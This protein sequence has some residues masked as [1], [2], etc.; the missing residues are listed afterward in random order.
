MARKDFLKVLTDVGGK[1]LVDAVKSSEKTHDQYVKR[2]TPKA[3]THPWR[4]VGRVRYVVPYERG[5][6]FACQ[7]G[8]VELHWIAN[9]CLRVRLRRDN[10]DFAEPFSYAVHKTEWPLV[11]FE[12]V[13]GADAVEVRSSS[14]I[15]RV[16]KRAFRI[17]LESVE[18]QPICLDLLG[19]TFRED[20]I[21]RLSMAMQP[22][23]SSFGLGEHASELMVRGKR[24]T[25]WNSDPLGYVRGTQPLY[26][27]IPFY[28]GIHQQAVYGVFWDNPSRGFADVGASK[29]DEL[30]L[31]SESG[32]LRY[33]LFTGNDV[34]SVVGR[35][36]ELT[37]RIPLPPLWSL[38]YHHASLNI[39][40]QNVLVQ[41]AQEFRAREIPCDALYLDLPHMDRFRSFTWDKSRFPQP[42][43]TLD[44][45]GEQGFKPVA[46][47]HPGVAVDGDNAIYNSGLSH[48]LFLKYPD[49][50]AV[51]GADWSGY[52]AFPDFTNPA[53]RG[54]W[55]ELVSQL[56][57]LG[58]QG[59]LNDA[60][61]PSR[62]A[63]DGTAS[64]AD[65]IPHNG[66]G[67]GGDHLSHHNLYGLLMSRASFEGQGRARPQARPFNLMRAGFAGG[68]R[69][70]GSWLGED[71]SDWDNLR[72]SISMA[73]NM[74]LSGAPVT[75]PNIGGFYQNATGELFTRWM[76][77]ACLM[78]FFRSHSA[79]GTQP[80]EPWAFGQPY[81][82]IN[83]LTIGLRYRLI[84][85]LY[86][87]VAQCREYGWP[88]IRPLFMTEPRNPDLRSIDDCYMLGDALLVAPV[89][90]QGA[91]K[92]MVYL[93]VGRWYDYWTGELLQG[94]QSVSIA[95]PLERLPLFVRAGAV[96]PHWPEMNYVGEKPIETLVYRVYPGEFETVLYEDDGHSLNYLE[97]DYRWIYIAS[98]WEENRFVIKRRV[99]GRYTP[100]YKNIK[101]E[102]IGFDQEP[103]HILVDRQGAPL[104]FYDDGLLELNMTSFETVEITRKS[105]PTDDTVS[106]RP[107][108]T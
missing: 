60:A 66:D 27:N 33:Y 75:G 64:L 69:W 39:A 19:M 56:A 30:V 77:A 37:G 61:E 81:E 86:S 4:G 31:E 102:V 9:D 108:R 24:F 14:L 10:G 80:Q 88:V 26:F 51:S 59:T 15:C 35:Y 6:R 83:R 57:G 97:G 18:Q 22:D 47:L 16:D 91:V 94:G 100:A 58:V 2:Y 96:L 84:P 38:G 107:R 85:Y 3:Q 65:F 103:S 62:L 90:T 32:E 23:E 29:R 20:G 12:Y 41:I 82:V 99:A 68:Q 45:L 44:S 21:V 5:I 95:A 7:N 13:E 55:A 89:L 36:N 42:K 1:R 79:L 48:N 74:G 98:G 46:V 67:L 43:A 52:C 70:G 76:Q 50:K 101:L 72:L 71:T 17:G 73:L 49:E 105:L 87:V 25:F 93:P 40:S 104:W 54:W 8:R 28:L 53:G 34:K 106:R 11:P 92:R 78:P 63:S